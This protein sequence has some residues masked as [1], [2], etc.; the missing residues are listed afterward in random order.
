MFKDICKVK[1][2]NFPLT[3]ENS[4]ILEH[5]QSIELIALILSVLAIVQFYLGSYFGKMIG[6]ETIQIFQFVSFARFLVITKKTTLLN[7]FHDL[8]YS[9]TGFS[10]P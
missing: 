6:L 7:A 4:F 5:F 9:S 2:A 8:K 10:S 1:G 3:V